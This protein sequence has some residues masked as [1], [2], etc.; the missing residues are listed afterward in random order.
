[1]Q[2]QLNAMTL[3]F[4]V[5]LL[6]YHFNYRTDQTSMGLMTKQFQILFAYFF[7]SHTYAP[8]IKAGTF[9]TQWNQLS[10]GTPLFKGHVL[11]GDAKFG[12]IITFT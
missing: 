6:Q 11:S 4:Q 3:N 1:M 10:F 7:N 5:K 8:H 9:S 2:C 12:P